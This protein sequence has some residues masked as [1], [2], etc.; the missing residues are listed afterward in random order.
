MQIVEK[1]IWIV[2]FVTWAI[3]VTCSHAQNAN[4]F[5]NINPYPSAYINDWELNPNSIGNLTIINNSGSSFEARLKVTVMKSSKGLILSS[6]SDFFTVENILTT[7]LDNT[8]I[9]KFGDV[10]FPDKDFKNKML[11]SGRIPE[12]EYTICINIEGSRN[13]IIVNNVCANFTILY[14]EPPHL[15]FPSNGME[16]E[17]S[18]QYP[19][20]Q[21]TPVVVPPNYQLRYVLKVVELL[22]GQIAS[23][24]INANVP[25]Y[26]NDN[27]T[28]NNLLYPPDALPLNTGKTYAWQVQVVDQYSLAPTQNN[29]KSEIF[30]FTRKKPLIFTV[31]NPLTLN[32]PDDEEVLKTKTPEFTWHYNPPIG[33]N[34]SYNLRVVKVEN[35]QSLETAIKNYPILNQNTSIQ[36]YK[37]SLPIAI[38]AGSNYAWRVIVKNALTG[39]TLR[40]SE[41]RKF[42]QF[43]LV[44]LLPGD[45]S[46]VNTKRPDFQWAYQGATGLY[47]D[48][49]VIKTP[50]IILP[51]MNIQNIMD[52]SQN[53]V[54]VKY[55]L[56]GTQLSSVNS[57]QLEIPILKP[58]SD[59][60]LEEAKSYLWQV[61][62]KTQQYGSV[63]A[64]SDIRQF[65][66]NPYQSGFATNCNVTG[67]LYYEFAKVGE[68]ST[69]VLKNVNVKFVI[70]YILKFSSHTGNNYGGHTES[71]GEFE[72]PIDALPPQY[73]NDYN[74]TIAIGKTDDGGNFS[75]SFMN[76]KQMGVINDNYNFSASG[77]FGYSYKGKIYR[78]IRTI[79]Q[80]PFYTSP[81]TDIIIQPGETKNYGQLI[82]N[83]RSYSLTVNVKSPGTW[84]NNQMLAANAPI[85]KMIVYM[86]RKNRPGEVP[87]NEGLPS[88]SVINESPF[89]GSYQSGYR[90]I[91]KTV[92]DQS[93]NAFFNRLVKSCYAQ[94]DEYFI[95]AIADSNQTSLIYKTFV[96]IS[97]S[98][99]NN[100]DNAVFNH[101]Y[102][103]PSVTKNIVAMPLNPVVKGKI[104]RADGGQPL[105]GV[106]V[107]LV[108]Y[109][110]IIWVDEASRVTGGNGV[111]RFDNLYNEYNSNGDPTGPIRGLK[112][113]KYGYRDTSLAVKSGA[114]LKPGDSWSRE[115]LLEPESK[116]I[117]KLVNEN[118]S[119]VSAMVSV[120]G[121]ESQSAEA[122]LII[123]FQTY[124]QPPASFELRAP[125]G[126]NKVVIDPMPY[127]NLYLKDTINVYVSGNTYDMGTVIVKKAVHRIK[128]FAG[129]Q[130][131]FQGEF[132]YVTAKL[133]NSKVMLQ[134]SDGNTID[135]KITNAGGMAEFMFANPAKN[136]LVTVTGPEN[137]NFE[138]KSYSFQ[139]YDSKDWK[140][141]PVLLKPAAQI[142][143][144]VYVGKNNQAVPNAHVKLKVNSNGVPTETYTNNQ[145]YYVLHNVP[146]GKRDYTASKKSSNLIGDKKFL[147]VP[148]AGV[149]NVNF[150]LK[151]YS[152]MDITHLMGFPIEVDSLSEK[153]NVVRITGKFVSLDSLKNNSFQAT[154]PELS[155]TNIVIVPD[156]KLTSVIFGNTVP[157][158]RPNILP[159]KTDNNQ[160]DLTVFDNYSGSVNDKNIG[161]EL[162][163]GQ[164]GSG[165]IK[166]KVFVSKSSFSVSSS[167]LD[168][169]DDGFYLTLPNSS[170]PKLSVITADMSS[171]V[172]GNN[173]GVINSEGHS[174]NYLLYGFNSFADSSKSFLYKDSLVLNTIL[175]TNIKGASPSDLNLSIGNIVI[176]SNSIKTISNNTHKISFAL[177]NWTLE[178]DK[179][180]LN[181]YI[182]A[183][184][185]TL[186]TNAVDIPL[187]GVYIKPDEISNPVLNLKSMNLGGVAPMNV[188]GNAM[189]GYETQDNKWY[190]T[191]DKGNQNYAASL[192]ALPG[193]EAQDSIHISS[194]SLYSDGTKNFS[195]ESQ[196]FKIYKVGILSLDQ[197]IAGDN[198]LEMSSLSFDIPKAGQLG[199]IIQ[200]YKE[201][202]QI[203]LKLLP[204]PIKISTNNVELAFGTDANIYPEYFDSQGLRVRGTVSE[205]GKFSLISW[206]YHT[207]DSTSIWVETPN[208][209]L[210][211]SSSWQKIEIGGANT[212][213]DEVNGNMKGLANSWND[214]WF[215][216]NLIVPSGIEKGK[217]NLK[218]TVLGN[219]VA[220]NQQL[221]VSG[222]NSSFGG[223]SLAY[224]PENKRF[225]GSL[226]VDKDLGNASIKGQA[227]AIVDSEGWY[228]FAG[229]E[230]HVYSP[231]TKGSAGIL[232]GHHPITDEMR[233]TFANY[234]YVYKHK[235]SL[236]KTFPS[237]L[238]GFYFEGMASI[239]IQSIIGLPSID[240][241]LVVVK[242]KLW[243]NAGADMRMGMDFN[244]GLTIGVGMDNFIEAGF[245][246][247][248]WAVVEC[249][250]V[251]C[252]ATLDIGSEGQFSTNGSWF[253]ELTGDITLTGSAYSGLGICDTD[254]SGTF[255]DEDSW[256][257]NKTFG[258]IG[259]IGSDGKYMNFYKK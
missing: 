53:P 185:G 194:F 190:L 259:H 124:K 104:K 101:E 85:G 90:V 176:T 196:T 142:S 18:A 73:Q 169:S 179:W 19:V 82:A 147:S 161:I 36:S 109:A 69:W 249:A 234:S 35:N 254:C 3:L 95:Y 21:W 173:F 243:V 216:G 25:Y 122:P 55:N 120:I 14:P 67:K 96:P 128:I 209:P 248:E 228:F 32:S 166:G 27:L 98:F 87:V 155:F 257:G 30:T 50:S 242:A 180:S 58:D 108:D 240:I 102:Q 107:K 100:G 156:P 39:D 45:K 237:S 217:N 182:T 230:L 74:K 145:G 84:W 97:Y 1:K 203:K 189:F 141:I 232:F 139:N 29:G 245:S 143:G 235:G 172:S 11:E 162:N 105:S 247:S 113:S 184:S 204:I 92:S 75:F 66:F 198:S 187:T 163:S 168:F 140:T 48:I 119:G 251:S 130:S 47:Y 65:T 42:T 52:N 223:I 159:L 63:I 222:V 49:K 15:V 146:I 78:V 94:N 175:H 238:N 167:T 154:Q 4:A 106:Q 244:N 44:L 137:Q 123:D 116:V 201:N 33:I 80:S 125:K 62:A 79:V 148:S 26:E 183:S 91:G 8:K 81:D 54:Y 252:G 231:D 157:V 31:Q 133:P 226:N 205:D 160:L 88:T 5:I 236:P 164:S 220:N 7:I 68:Y 6:V 46:V 111:F 233:N 13:N 131:K 195:P 99:K 256:S 9:I 224:E 112:I 89:F 76:T 57:S 207:K 93:G 178:I 118:G 61:S 150:H 214:F 126:F 239:P 192:S 255:C 221:G 110:L 158:S 200:Y 115:V 117:G 71:Q 181:G 34:V 20:F 206:L 136:Y 37:P 12:G 191:V 16:L 51:N 2:I 202:N 225:I 77:E 186:K 41:I 213:L 17:N 246:V 177:G 86:L 10:S 153:N 28:T 59:L 199:A 208:S 43:P 171:P 103:Y 193:M 241:D 170:D 152:E 24:A 129:D 38:N 83:V 121:G 40:Q 151:I 144:Y 197:L 210:S 219:I 188:V 258:I 215:S 22:Q 70:K 64:K 134:T 135:E 211:Q 149:Q 127:S 138:I 165:V 253:A 23:Q 114:V 60:P 218:F 72:I 174:I 212:Y 56:S 229:G 227:N 132:G 250:G